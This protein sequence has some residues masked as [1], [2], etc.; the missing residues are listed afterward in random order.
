MIAPKEMTAGKL[1]GLS[2]ERAELFGKPHLGAHYEGR[3]DYS[4]K[5]PAKRKQH[6][7]NDGAICPFCGGGPASEAHHMVP[8]GIGGGS[9]V[10]DFR[11]EWGEFILLSP[12]FGLCSKHHR[13]FTEGHLSIRWDWT[14]ADAMAAWWSGSLLAHG[15]IPHDQRLW[16]FGRYIVT[17]KETGRE[18][19]FRG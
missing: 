17:A 16:E 3:V 9:L 2:Y 14:D 4:L 1:D 8:K 5:Y 18:V 10:F 11:T 15:Y 13:F 12:L 7:L 6:R 19:V